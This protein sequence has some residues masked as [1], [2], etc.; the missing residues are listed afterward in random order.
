LPSDTAL[1]ILQSFTKGKNTKVPSLVFEEF[2]E[3][4]NYFLELR[5]KFDKADLDKSETISRKEI[6]ALLK[7]LKLELAEKTVADLMTEFDMGIPSLPP[8]PLLFFSSF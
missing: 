4:A 2:K 7:D 1:A 6:I 3:L 5:R 8:P